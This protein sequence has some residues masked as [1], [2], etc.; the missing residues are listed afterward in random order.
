MAELKSSQPKRYDKKLFGKI[1]S[2]RSVIG[3]HEL[4]LR[5]GLNLND[6]SSSSFTSFQKSEESFSLPKLLSNR[7]KSAIPARIHFESNSILINEFLKENNPNRKNSSLNNTD[8]ARDDMMS[9][10]SELVGKRKYTGNDFK[11]SYVRGIVRRHSSLNSNE[12][13]IHPFRKKSRNVIDSL[14][15][16]KS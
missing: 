12:L 5:G 7:N 8:G 6:E 9:V 3:R 2:E 13:K 16:I 11:I 1:F 10:K 4:L 15:F 14:R